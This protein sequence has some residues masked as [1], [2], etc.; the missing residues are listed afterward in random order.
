MARSSPT[1]PRVVRACNETG[2]FRTAKPRRGC[3]FIM[4]APQNPREFR[5]WPSDREPVRFGHEVSARFF[6]RTEDDRFRLTRG[7]PRGGRSF[8]RRRREPRPPTARVGFGQR[9]AERTAL[10]RPRHG[11]PGGDGRWQTSNTGYDF[12]DHRRSRRNLSPLAFIR[13]KPIQRDYSWL[14]DIPSGSPFRQEAIECRISPMRAVRERCWRGGL[15]IGS[16]TR[17]RGMA[18]PPAYCF[19]TLETI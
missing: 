12:D 15:P 13:R 10:L 4:G 8:H 11:Q 17:R 9:G 19:F 14:M 16:N 7:L 1:S 6:I 5:P 18:I 3:H 2:D